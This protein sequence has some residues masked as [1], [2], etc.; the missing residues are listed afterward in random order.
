MF[1]GRKKS[2]TTTT[3]TTT[4]KASETRVISYE[5]SPPKQNRIVSQG[6]PEYGFTVKYDPILGFSKLKN[7]FENRKNIL[8]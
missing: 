1:L 6:D 5:G 7:I 2:A 8:Q 4:K 3:T